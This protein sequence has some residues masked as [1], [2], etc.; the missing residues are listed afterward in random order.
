MKVILLDSLGNDLTVVNAARVSF[1]KVSEEFDGSDE[2]LVNYLA[3]HNH[4]TP[5]SHVQYQVRISAPIF[6]ARQWFK[7]QI[8]ITRNEV[9]RRYVSD[10]PQFHT[11]DSWRMRPDNMKQGSEGR[12]PL[13]KEAVW[14]L[15]IR[16]HHNACLNMYRDMVADGICPEQA[17]MVLPQSM[18]TEWVETG[19]LTAAARVASLRLDSHAQAEIQELA[20]LYVR[21]IEGIAPYSWKALT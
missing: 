18:M 17:R 19:S 4:W 8:G 14:D 2:K 20:K 7:H 6:V 5:F 3:S 15:N 1:N 9:S 12:L 11:P 21:E 10:S 16:E 13:E